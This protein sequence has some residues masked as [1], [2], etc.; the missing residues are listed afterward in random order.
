MDLNKEEY[1]KDLIEIKYGNVKFFSEHAGLKYTTVRSILE[2]GVLNAK[3]ENVIKICD[4][5]GIKPEDILKVEDSIINDTNKKMIQLNPDRQQNVYNYADNQL[6]EQNSKVVNLPLVGK[7]AA[8]PAEL[9]YGDVEIEHD[10][11][12]DV[13]HGADTAIRIQGDSMEPLI[14][15]GQIIFYHQQEEVENGEI[16]IVEIDGD[17]VT[18]KQIYYDY[19]SD[20]VILRSINKKYE[21]RHVKDDQ[22]RIIG[23][24]IL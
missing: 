8:N 3:V 24:V 7:S 6:K 10:D 13:P 1:L 2:R 4:A 12:T 21:P 19:T 9:T 14:H 23:K 5:L 17:G 15:D 22:V 11:F 20:E 18:C 16:A